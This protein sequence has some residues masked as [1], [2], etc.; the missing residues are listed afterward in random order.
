MDIKDL[1]VLAA[2]MRTKEEIAQSLQETAQAVILGVDPDA[3]REL[4]MHCQMYLVHIMTDGNMEKAMNLTK[5]MEEHKK[6]S[7]M[8]NPSKS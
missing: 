7:D 3:D 6:R 2:T 8:F 4:A 1:L 5:E